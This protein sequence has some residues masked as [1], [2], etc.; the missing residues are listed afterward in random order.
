MTSTLTACPAYYDAHPH[1]TGW[2]AH[3]PC[4]WTDTPTTLGQAMTNGAHHRDT[5]AHW[6]GHHCRIHP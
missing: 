5:C 1:P 4:G 3:C 6:A 2:Q